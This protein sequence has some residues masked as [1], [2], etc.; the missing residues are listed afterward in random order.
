MQIRFQVCQFGCAR[1]QKLE[2]E[3]QKQ[4]NENK[5]ITY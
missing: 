5:E 3:Q 1:I 2:R 4:N